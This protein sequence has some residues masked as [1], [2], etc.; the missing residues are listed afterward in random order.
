M[1]IVKPFVNYDA[2]DEEIWIHNYKTCENG[3]YEYMIRKPEGFEHHVIH[4]K[5][6]DGWMVLTEKV[7]RILN[8][9]KQIK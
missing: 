4:H 7:L 2:I 5:R 6:T 8:N 1:L 9:E 3:I